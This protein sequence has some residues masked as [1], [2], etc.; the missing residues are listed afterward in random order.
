[1][2]FT[3][4]YFIN[5]LFHIVAFILDRLYFGIFFLGGGEVLS[6]QCMCERVFHWRFIFAKF[7]QTFAV[8]IQA[9]GVSPHWYRQ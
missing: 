7:T 5:L 2:E 9:P 6:D 3:F 4:N 1:M 8:L